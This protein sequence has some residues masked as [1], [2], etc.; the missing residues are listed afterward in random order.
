MHNYDHC[1]N[2]HY[3]HDHVEGQEGQQVSRS[4]KLALTGAMQNRPMELISLVLSQFFGQDSQTEMT[5]SYHHFK[6]VFPKHTSY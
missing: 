6:N 4:L 2:Y 3:D 5:P 1:T